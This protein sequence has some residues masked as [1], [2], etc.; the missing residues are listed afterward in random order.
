[1]GLLQYPSKHTGGLWGLLLA[2]TLLPDGVTGLE[3][4]EKIVRPDGLACPVTANL[5]PEQERTADSIRF[6]F[7]EG[8]IPPP[9]FDYAGPS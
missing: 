2:L 5:S 4:Q 6:M 9:S 1:M 3:A 7:P 8:S